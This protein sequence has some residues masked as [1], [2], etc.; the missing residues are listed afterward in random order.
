M[1]SAIN[2][3]RT[4]GLTVRGSSYGKETWK[5]ASGKGN[6]HAQG[7]LRFQCVNFLLAHTEIKQFKRKKKPQ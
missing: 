4:M 6:V 1:V 5:G 2:A 3:V 7:L